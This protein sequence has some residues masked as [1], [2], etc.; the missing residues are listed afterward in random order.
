MRITRHVPAFVPALLAAA[1]IFASALPGA[2]FTLKE[3]VLVDSYEKALK[4]GAQHALG[5]MRPTA[6]YLSSEVQR[7]RE[8]EPLDGG[9]IKARMKAI[10]KFPLLD[11]RYVTVIDLWITTDDKAIYLTRYQMHSDNNRVPILLS[12]DER[13]RV[14]LQTLGMVEVKQKKDDF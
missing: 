3:Q 8:A 2:A 6:E 5:E 12:T 1:L 13:V 11:D 14:L 9:E 4:I 7:I 10:W